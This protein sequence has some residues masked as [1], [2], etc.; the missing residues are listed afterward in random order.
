MQDAKSQRPKQSSV[1][2]KGK[3]MKQYKM[4][5]KVR[6]HPADKDEH[7]ATCPKRFKTECN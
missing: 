2:T 7:N 5:N 4:S 1:Q 6:H 3:L